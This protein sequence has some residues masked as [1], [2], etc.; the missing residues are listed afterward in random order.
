MSSALN[1]V[2][3]GAFR[4]GGQIQPQDVRETAAEAL[5]KTK[6]EVDE[7]LDG[8]KPTVATTPERIVLQTRAKGAVT[9]TTLRYPYDPGLLDRDSDYV[10]F[11]FWDYTP[12]ISNRGSQ[13][14][15]GGAYGNYNQQSNK[16]AQGLRD[17]ILYMPQDV[18][19]SFGAGWD[20]V[21]LS[22]S[23]IG[24]IQTAFGGADIG[25]GLSQVG[26]NLKNALTSSIRSL[27][28]TGTGSN[29]TLNQTLSGVAGQIVNPNTELLYE[30]AKLRRFN[31][32][33]KMASGSS[34]ESVMIRNIYNQFKKATLPGFGASDYSGDKGNGIFLTVPKLVSVDFMTGPQRNTYL[35]YY[36]L[37]GITN[38]DLNFTADGTWAAFKN[39]DPVS[40][41]MRLGFIETKLVFS[42]EVQNNG[43]GI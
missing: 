3:G 7:I 4:D 38:L 20:G 16:S 28:N 34:D 15:G 29:L 32:T 37:C 24:A 43:S 40:V 27:I 1:A 12:P 9:D 13:T 2:L 21:G 17:V 19:T 36:K 31:L 8:E 14:E 6:E 41:E 26:G 25:L 18:Q 30:A 22:S 23:Q 39:G 35:P 11:R 10:M 5:G 42:N 33:F